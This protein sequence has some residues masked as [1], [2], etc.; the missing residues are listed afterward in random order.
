MSEPGIRC[1]ECAVH[2][3]GECGA[4][5]MCLAVCTNGDDECEHCPSTPCPVGER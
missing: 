2:S 5:C 1:H 3:C 4:L